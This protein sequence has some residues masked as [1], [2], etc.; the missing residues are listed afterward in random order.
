MAIVEEAGTV[1][2]KYEIPE[3]IDKQI[4]LYFY[5][6]LAGELV[7][8]MGPDIMHK[9]SLYKCDED[10]NYI[11][12]EDGSYIIEDEYYDLNSSTGGWYEAFNATC[13]KLN[14][15]WLLEYWNTLEW[16]DS[17]IFDGII[18]DRVVNYFIKNKNHN[19]NPYYK[20]LVKKNS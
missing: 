1:F 3:E 9:I 13:N 14:M 11:L 8:I 17:D 18:E 2:V 10:F 7:S 16:Y 19:A 20:Y 6:A 15:K 5:Y 12:N 4:P